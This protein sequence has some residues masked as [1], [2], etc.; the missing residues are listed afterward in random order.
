MIDVSVV[1]PVW[2]QEKYIKQA[3]ESTFN[4]EC[5]IQVVVIDDGSTD[6]TLQLVDSI[7]TPSN[8]SMKVIKQDHIGNMGLTLNRAYEQAIGNIISELGSD[9]YYLP[10]AL[11]T[12]VKTMNS[13]PSNVG[14]IYSG[15]YM[16][17]EGQRTGPV[18]GSHNTYYQWINNPEKRLLDNNFVTPPCAIRRQVYEKI[19]YDPTQEINED[20]LLKLELSRVTTFLQIKK[21]LGVLRIRSDSISNNPNTKDRMKYWEDEA[22]RKVIE[23]HGK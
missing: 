17:R 19:R 14:L 5:S 21:P 22:R 8:V 13:S 10:G 20:Y 18:P 6:R 11:D 15:Y 7:S 12:L 1:I 23:R 4:N 2:N 3:I 9:D 16:D